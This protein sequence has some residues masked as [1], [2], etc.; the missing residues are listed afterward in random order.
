LSRCIFCHREGRNR[1]NRKP[2]C[3]KHTNKS[4]GL[5]T[6]VDP[7]DRLW[8]HV[9]LL[10][11]L[12][13]GVLLGLA[14]GLP[15]A[16]IAPVAGISLRG[17]RKPKEPVN[18]SDRRQ[19]ILMTLAG[20]GG[21]LATLFLSGKISFAE[22][23]QAMQATAV[24]NPSRLTGSINGGG[25]NYNQP[26]TGSGP[27]DYLIGA[28]P[29]GTVYTAYS[30]QGVVA[31]TDSTPDIGALIY[32]ITNN[33]VPTQALKIIVADPPSASGAYQWQT[34]VTI[35]TDYSIT[36]DGATRGREENVTTDNYS[37]GV[38]FVV[39]SLA[40]G[41]V[42]L[43][44][45][46]FTHNLGMARFSNFT[47]RGLALGNTSTSPGSMYGMVLGSSLTNCPAEIEIDNV[48]FENVTDPLTINDAHDGPIIITWIMT[49]NCGASST[50]N[51]LI[52]IACDTA[53]IGHI[54]GFNAVPTGGSLVGVATC[55][56]ISIDSIYCSN[57]TA[58]NIG[59][60]GAVAAAYMLVGSCIVGG[61]NNFIMPTSTSGLF[62]VHV[63]SLDMLNGGAD[64]F[65]G[66]SAG[67]GSSFNITIDKFRGKLTHILNNSNGLAGLSGFVYIDN[68]VL[69]SALTPDV[70]FA[71]MT[72]FMK[73]IGSAY[74]RQSLSG[75]TSGTAV[76]GFDEYA[77]NHK[78]FKVYLNAYY[79]S[80]TPAQTITFPYSFADTPAIIYQPS[81]FGA[82]T[83]KTVLSLPA[84]M[85]AAATGW[86][87]IE[88]A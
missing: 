71:G 65:A 20:G 49:V 4:L 3:R 30:S 33:G 35:T 54:E 81:S 2:V 32:N 50:S 70:V 48:S 25:T 26:S 76:S 5:F 36:I 84:S 46:T 6:A 39:S 19:L 73:E 78:K 23:Q 53:W 57:M 44:I 43:T 88:G 37:Y 85:G 21:A 69:G 52:T 56:L 22:Y 60:G 87:I 16:G 62:T 79:N 29:A 64:V 38:F 8:L 27:Y 17:R 7:P 45:N 14:H 59:N 83:T 34:A 41:V 58:F 11:G 24:G 10:S 47:M 66:G 40:A 86:I 18:S 55:A 75:S 51:S 67:S 31:A 72:S 63:D 68:A 74:T 82:T 61:G 28:N 42:P 1:I 13:L 12:V 77:T 15:F 80:G 9:L